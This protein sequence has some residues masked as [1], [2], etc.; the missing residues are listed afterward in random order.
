MQVTLNVPFINGPTPGNH[1]V[2]TANDGRLPETRSVNGGRYV[3]YGGP[4]LFSGGN[5]SYEHPEYR[6]SPS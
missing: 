3:L 1:D 2:T 5:Y 4:R 6:F